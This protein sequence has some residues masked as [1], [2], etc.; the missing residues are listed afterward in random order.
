MMREVCVPS[1]D[2]FSAHEKI[3]NYKQ[4]QM[5]SELEHSGM[6]DGR[7]VINCSGN[8]LAASALWFIH[9]FW[10][11]RHCQHFAWRLNGE[12]LW[13]DTDV[14]IWAGVRRKNVNKI[15]LNGPV[16]ITTYNLTDTWRT[17]A[18][19]AAEH[20]EYRLVQYQKIFLSQWKTF[21]VG[22]ES[23]RASLLISEVH[24]TRH[25]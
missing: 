1:T 17:M 25:N 3:M 5:A 7:R 12:Q 21:R 6:L 16:T 14:L 18:D 15:R 22:V 20:E 23:A 2:T 19:H 10:F 11:D 9:C 24:L 8:S 13:P 4:R